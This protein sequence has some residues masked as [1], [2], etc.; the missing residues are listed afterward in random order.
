MDQPAPLT[1]DDLTDEQLVEGFMHTY[2]MTRPAAERQAAIA[3]GDI[4]TDI[5]EKKP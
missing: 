3:R 2:G 1:V 5:V 4:P